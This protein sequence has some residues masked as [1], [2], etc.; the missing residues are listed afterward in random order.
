MDFQA[1]KEGTSTTIL[2]SCCKIALICD[3][4]SKAKRAP[5]FLPMPRYQLP[6][7][8][9]KRKNQ[10]SKWSLR[11]EIGARSTL[12]FNSMILCRSSALLDMVCKSLVKT[13]RSHLLKIKS[14]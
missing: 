2:S 14:L 7:Q 1:P 8:S 9:I 10:N 5:N 11:N 3:Q 12:C 13:T 4:V 6:M